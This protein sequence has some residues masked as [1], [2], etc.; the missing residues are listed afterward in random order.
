MKNTWIQLNKDYRNKHLDCGDYNALF[1]CRLD[2][3]ITIFATL[4]FGLMV[5]LL[6]VM[7]ETAICQGAR[8]RIASISNVSVQSVFSQFSRPLSDE[9]EI[10]GGVIYKEE[11]VEN[12][13]NRY[14]Y[15]N[16]NNDGNVAS[17]LI[18]EPYGIRLSETNIDEIKLL[19]DDDGKRFYNQVVDYMKLGQFT[20]NV[21]EMLNDMEKVAQNNDAKEV[22]DELEQRH[23]DACEIDA[24][25]LKLLMQVEGI[26]TTKSGFS[27]FFGNL[28]SAG[29]FVKKLCVNGTDYGRTAV[30][31]T[32]VYNTV[33]D[34]YYDL[35]NKLSDLKGELDWI[36][37]VYNYPLTK[38]QFIDLGYRFNAGLICEEVNGV[39]KKI[40]EALETISQIE[41]K[42]GNLVSKL[43]DS[44][45]ILGKN[46]GKM[47]KEM[48]DYYN[49]EFNELG[50][51]Q[52]GD[53]NSLC[54]IPIIKQQLLKCKES[55]SYISNEVYSLANCQMDIT[56]IDLVYGQIDECIVNCKSYPAME[57]KFNY[58]NV[59][60]G[61][62]KEI[63]YLEKIKKYFSEGVMS[64]VIEDMSKV[65]NKKVIL[66]D[67]S[68]MFCNFTNCDY[69]DIA[70]E[71]STIYKDFLYNKYLGAYFSSYIDGDE[72]KEKDM[73]IDYE[74]EYILSGKKMDRENLQAAIDKILLVRYLFDFSYIVCDMEKKQKCYD[75]A[76]LLLGFTGVYGVIKAGQYFLLSAW[77]YSEALSDVKILLKGNKIAL[78]KSSDNW[79]SNL[80]SVI[81]GTMNDN[82]EGDAKGID[83]ETYLQLLYFTQKKSQKTFFTMDAMEMHMASLGY[84]HI[85]MYKYLNSLKGTVSYMY[86]KGKYNYTQKIE[87]AY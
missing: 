35:P 3:Q 13:L 62:G 2:G 65:S 6:V 25:I 85:R 74:M 63:S 83:Y 26:K 8:N 52:T 21:S 20:D 57:I 72:N 87:F 4:I 30:D 66:T 40:D 37:Y 71:L 41:I 44:K 23:K 34:K 50:K 45:A 75:M 64:L 58:E 32:M 60:L 54:N 9:Y 28:S 43:G 27:Q 38:G 39:A 84:G 1:H 46:Q 47:T 80:E 18:F 70:S 73:L 36:K 31:N 86:R 76:V 61:K 16:C 22:S 29:T 78:K 55:I 14:I 42:S 49:Q 5:S 53:A 10:F 48:S 33:K 68:S 69:S 15:D 81:E 17:R 19:T 79:R 11:E 12:L 82:S 24:L 51:Y 67:L 7:I 77:A 56:T 59:S